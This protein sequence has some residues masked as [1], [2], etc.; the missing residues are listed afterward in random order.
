ML[1]KYKKKIKVASKKLW[2]S[3][4][5]ILP[6]SAETR[7][8]ERWGECRWPCKSLRSKRWPGL[9]HCST[10]PECLW[11]WLTLSIGM[12]W[13]WSTWQIGGESTSVGHKQGSLWTLP[14]CHLCFH[15]SRPYPHHHL[16]C[17]LLCHQL[18]H[19]WPQQ[20]W[21]L[22]IEC[23]KDCPNCFPKVTE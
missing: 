22:K 8:L 2:K 19:H 4:K 20:S 17:W 14:I 6:S 21:A 23:R 13:R 11:W 1:D 9:T 12:S 15:Y 3:L 16:H 18:C 10:F 7:M 5:A